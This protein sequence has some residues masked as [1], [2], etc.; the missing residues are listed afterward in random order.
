VREE[1]LD[2]ILKR[3]A[4]EPPEV[5]PEVLSRIA[6][7]VKASLTPVRP[8]P[9]R[10]QLAGGVLLVCVAVSLAGAARS[11]LFGFA[12]MDS[13]ERWL[14]FCLLGLFTWAAA[15]NFVRSMIPGS[16][17]SLSTGSLMGWTC[18]A[19]LGV[20]ALLFRDYATH[21]FFAAGVACLLTGLLYA[22]PAALISWLVL[23]RGFAVD[24]V[25]AGFSAGLLGGLA[26]VAMLELH[27]PNFEAAHVLVWHIAVVPVSGALGAWVGWLLRLRRAREQ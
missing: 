7:S 23:R 2:Q 17:R 14:I 27:C 25:T 22:V 26:G 1:E 6:D 20:F 11:G 15:V 5:K 10:W 13:L 18:L 4:G 24:P 9:S 19:M 8:L 12:R 16:R 3:S 21:N